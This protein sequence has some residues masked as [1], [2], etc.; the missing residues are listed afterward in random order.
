MKPTK[1]LLFTIILIL[2]LQSWSK[3]DDI[4]D[5]QIEGMS[6]GDSLLDF[7][8]LNQ[9]KKF[10][11]TDYKNSKKFYILTNNTK[12][13]MYDALQFSLKN[14]DKKYKIFGMG[15]IIWFE[16]NVSNCL[17]KKNEIE[18]DL[19]TIFNNSKIESF[20]ERTLPY[21]Q[22]GKSKQIAQTQYNVD[23]GLVAIE[24]TDFSENLS[25]EKGYI[26]NLKIATYSKEY[27]LFVR[28]AY[29]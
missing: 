21:D 13:T 12:S 17:I 4:R 27:E 7:F 25:N 6:I 20:G 15:G 8:T 5:F 24:C 16:K 14:N 22:S 23:N 9:I 29:D 1:I 3:A 11:R 28:N 10:H 2:S 26:D 18:K 19:K